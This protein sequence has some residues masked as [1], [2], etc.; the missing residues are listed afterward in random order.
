[1]IEIKNLNKEINNKEILT[2]ICFEIYKGDFVSVIGPSGSGKT[3]LLNILLLII[4]KTSGSYNFNGKNIDEIKFDNNEVIKFRQNIG[5]MSSLSQLLPNINV[6]QNIML[7][8]TI[9][10]EE[11][12][13][14][15]EKLISQL[16]IKKIQN[17]SISSLSSG[18]KQRVLL[19]RALILSPL[20]LIADEP[21]ANLDNNNA[22]KIG[23]I[24]S[25]LNEENKTTIIIA[26]HDDKISNK[27]KSILKIENGNLSKEI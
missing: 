7:P 17:N 14:D 9:F 4:D 18:E 8:A 24:M 13:K 20:L 11:R 3:T 12:S 2:N 26:T 19:A 5:I 27:T 6:K 25:D 15:Y 10:E 22:L 1:M 16:N 21:T 23:D